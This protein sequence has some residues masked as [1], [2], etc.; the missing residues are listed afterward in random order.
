MPNKQDEQWQKVS[1]HL[2]LILN[3]CEWSAYLNWKELH[4]EYEIAH[5]CVQKTEID[6]LWLGDIFLSLSMLMKVMG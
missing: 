1:I 4:P 5:K 3:Y 6:Q 2:W